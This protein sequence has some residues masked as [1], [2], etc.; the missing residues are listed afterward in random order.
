MNVEHNNKLNETEIICPSEI[1]LDEK[2][3]YNDSILR[4]LKESQ[5]HLTDKSNIL[6][7]SL[8]EFSNRYDLDDRKIMK[9][10]KFLISFK[11]LI[12]LI[13]FALEFQIKINNSLNEYFN[14]ISQDFIN[15]LSYYIFSFDKIDVCNQNE[16]YTNNSNNNNQSN[17]DKLNTINQ[18]NN[19]DK[20][21]KKEE[22]KQNIYRN[23]LIRFDKKHKNIKEHRS[24]YLNVKSPVSKNKKK[25]K[26]EAEINYSLKNNKSAEKRTRSNT[27]FTLDSIKNDE[28]KKKILNKSTEKRRNIKQNEKTLSKNK[29]TNS[30]SI[31]TACENI[32]N[33]SLIIKVKNSR[34]SSCV[35]QNRI[36]SKKNTYYNQCKNY[37]IKKEILS[38][39][40][41]RPSNMANKLLQKG[42]KYINDF[43]NLKEEECKKKYY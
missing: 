33:S 21:K 14:E 2:N 30:F 22:E 12:N 20:K 27:Y 9:S 26:E 29:N 40:I 32:K 4:S 42:I 3:T 11:D 34:K 24:L 7:N 18:K 41:I 8:K 43:A 37:A 6:L 1:S 25:I 16:C 13:K 19:K 28:N 17:N 10:K 38:N 36:N 23:K 35:E 15:N 39:N 31:F 5:Y